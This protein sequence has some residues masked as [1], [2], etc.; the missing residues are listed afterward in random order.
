MF[1]LNYKITEDDVK[2]INFSIMIAYFIPYLLVSLLGLGAGIAAVVLRPT[3]VLFVLGIVL[4][5]LGAILFGCAILLLIV[6]KNFITSA[7]VPSS[8]TERNLKV[9][10]NGMIVTTENREPVEIPFYA[11]S[12]VKVKLDRMLVYLGRDRVLVVKDAMVTGSFEELCAF[13]KSRAGSGAPSVSDMQNAQSISSSDN[14]EPKIAAVEN[15]NSAE[16]NQTTASPIA[17]PLQAE[18]A[19]VAENAE[20]AADAESAVDTDNT[21][22]TAAD[23]ESAEEG[24]VDAETAAVA[25]IAEKSETT[26]GAEDA[27]P[28]EKT[29]ATKSTAAKSG[30]KSTTAK[31]TGAKSTTVKSGTKSAATKSGAKSTTAKPTAKKTGT[32]TAAAKATVKAKTE[33]SEKSEH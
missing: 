31:T 3:Q 21:A 2:K 7:L 20:S 29:V 18:S 19:D 24:R 11:V 17:E 32:K 26:V 16:T 4:L 25:D 6:P 13:V 23:A 5:V 10:D 1:E 12:R 8:E 14:E 22:D 15:A 33:D 27:A 28:V 30:V 9:D